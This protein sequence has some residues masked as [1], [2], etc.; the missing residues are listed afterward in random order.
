MLYPTAL[1]PSDTI[2]VS[3]PSGTAVNLPQCYLAFQKW[4]GKLP[5]FDFGSKP[6]I[7][8]KGNGVFAELAVL[9]MFT[10]AGWEGVWVS[11]YGGIHYLN[12]RPT[13]W[14]LS[15]HNISIPSEKKDLLR[16]IWE[17]GKTRACFDVFVWKDN[18]ILF[19]EVKHKGKDKLTKAQSKFIAGALSSGVQMQSLL[20]AE[21]NYFT[22]LQA[23]QFLEGKVKSL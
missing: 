11:T 20:I 3:L 8:Y 16:D 18:N 17:N 6:I 23:A 21:W 4:S 10:D 15:L 2:K 12:K 7:N 19:C 14:D 1:T 9:R 13:S 22:N 5:C